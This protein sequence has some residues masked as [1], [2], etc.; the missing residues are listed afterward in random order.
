MKLV[1]ANLILILMAVFTIFASADNEVFITQS[2]TNAQIEIDQI[3][4]GNTVEGNEAAGSEPISDF[5]LTG[6]SQTIDIDQVG[7]SNIFRGD[8][9]SDTFTGNF[10]F[11]G[12]SNEFDIQFDPAGSYISDNIEMDVDITG[13]SNDLTV[14][15]ATNDSAANL[16]YDAVISGDY[17]TWVT[18][19]DS[20]NVTFNVDVNGDNGSIDYDADGYAVNSTGHTFI[21]DQDGDYVD[22]TIDQQSTSAVDYL[23]LQMTTSGTSGSEANICVYQSDNATST[24]C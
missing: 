21:L 23:N 6:N 5:K 8:I 3:G 1:G 13:S 11:Q 16:D 4:S 2:G 14:N 24:S 19:I 22:Y 10:S 18:N 17:N 9:D 15:I 7:D 12:S 20:D